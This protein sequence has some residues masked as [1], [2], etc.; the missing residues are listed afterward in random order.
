[1]I[2][3]EKQRI[4]GEVK[5]LSL[6]QSQNR[7]AN[8]VGVSSSTISQMV[9]GNW[10]LIK[11]EMWR[12]VKVRLRIDLD[13][14]IANTQMHKDLVDFMGK[15]QAHQMTIA[16]SH[17]AGTGKTTA[18]AN[19]QK[20]VPEVIY[21]EGSRTL[22]KKNYLKKLL[23]NAGQDTFGTTE[24]LLERFIDHVSGLAKPL[25]IIDQFDK[26]KDNTFDLFMD[27]YN[28]LHGH[29]GF[30]LSGVEAL[31]KRVKRGVQ[32]KRSGYDEIWSRMD[33]KFVE[34][35]KLSLNDVQAVFKANGIDDEDA[36][37]SSFENCDGDLRRVRKDITKIKHR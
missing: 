14:K 25:I 6:L 3:T 2:T 4:A 20:Q 19:Y 31:E 18:F 12:K 7:I 23:A 33:R 5:R 1:M 27:F 8:R 21:V 24:D 26:L 15:A 9:N 36:A 22:S 28:E 35:A 16:F 11:P 34:L 29:C 13:W 30:I 32:L 10:T 37:L 17:K